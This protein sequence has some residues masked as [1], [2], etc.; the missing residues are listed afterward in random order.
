M[1]LSFSYNA[2][3]NIDPGI[4]KSRVCFKASLRYPDKEV[5]GLFDEMEKQVITVSSGWSDDI[6]AA[7]LLKNDKY[8]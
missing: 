2:V 3:V 8:K 5:A 6:K 4:D 1:N 7:W